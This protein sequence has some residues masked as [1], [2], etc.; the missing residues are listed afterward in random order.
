MVLNGLKDV[1]SE[2]K[3][4]KNNNYR[5]PLRARLCKS[6]HLYVKFQSA[7]QG[8]SIESSFNL[9]SEPFMQNS[10]YFMQSVIQ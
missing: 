8:S 1:S 10:G 6:A 9:D 5:S 7:N 2:K 3:T 4:V